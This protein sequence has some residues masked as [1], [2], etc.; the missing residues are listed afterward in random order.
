MAQPEPGDVTRLLQ[1]WSGGDQKA[2]GELV[3]LVYR[4]LRGLAA[5]YIRRERRD[6]T[7][8]PTAL[9]HEAYLR[10]ADQMHVQSP[11]RAQFFA[12]AANLM[13]QILVNHARHHR[14]AKRGGGKKVP[15]EE[16]AAMVQQRGVD[17][18]AL[19]SALEKLA[20]LDPRQSRIVELRFF[21]GLTEEEIAEVVGVS[22]ITVKRDW[23]IARAVLHRQLGTDVLVPVEE[24]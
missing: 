9:V 24:P 22:A 10:L 13:R 18:I 7:L 20:Q 19:D 16:G 12:I 2:L 4:E 8:Q 11:S 17:L 23:R 15:L 21:G 3:P 14:A 6:H 5:A 1:S